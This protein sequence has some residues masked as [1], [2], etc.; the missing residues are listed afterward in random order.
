MNRR[1][2]I[3]ALGAC[4]AL[5]ALPHM[6]LAAGSPAWK[7]GF[8]GVSGDL[9]PLSLKVQGAVPED[10]SGRLYRNGP[11]LYERGGRRYQHWFDPDGMIQCYEFGPKGVTHQGRLVRT[12]KLQQEER[13]GRFLF[14]GAGTH[15]ADALPARSNEDG[16]VANISIQPLNG[17]LLAL[18]EAGS[19]HRID[20]QTLETLGVKHWSDELKGV[21]FSAHP[22]FDDNGDLWNIGSV[23]FGARPMLVLYHVAKDGTLRNA[24]LHQLEFPGYMHDFVLTPRYLVALNNSAV[25]GAGDTFVD[26]MRWNPSQPSQLLV[27]DRSDLSLQATIEVPAT[28]VFHF[29]NGWEQ[30]REISFTGCAYPDARIMSDGMRLL[31]QQ[32]S[33]AY[34]TGA[35]LVR[36]TIDLPA[37]AA[38]VEPLG[39]VMEFPGFDQRQPF[40]AQT[41]Y[42][43]AGQERSE[44]SLGSAVVAV[45]PLTGK[46]DR[47]DYGDGVVVEEPLFV[48]GKGNNYLVHSYLDYRAGRTGVA[49]LDAQRL[50]SGPLMRA[51]MDRVTPLGFHGC[52]LPGA[53]ASGPNSA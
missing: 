35:E 27:F 11:A 17:E 12:A 28:F 45:D 43:S 46:Q 9:S 48:P 26:R 2:F 31:A 37:R 4:P 39:V 18:W 32:Q 13:A 33:G 21:P 16:N 51:E 50:A 3:Q 30:G 5:Q 52:F 53:D 34:H 44:S 22:H 25:L 20:P 7:L 38:R 47:F 49:L 24:R 41:L 42:G 8:D 10:F 29:G 1:E 23:P 36:Y 15:F 19:A 6:A 14:D 40:R